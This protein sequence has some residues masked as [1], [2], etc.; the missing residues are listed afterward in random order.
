MYY[1]LRYWHRSVWCVENTQ[2]TINSAHLKDSL[3]SHH[4]R[5]FFVQS[6]DAGNMAIIIQKENQLGRSAQ[7]GAFFVHPVYDRVEKFAVLG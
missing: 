3:Q 1:Q 4:W 5:N 7:K 6:L 2:G